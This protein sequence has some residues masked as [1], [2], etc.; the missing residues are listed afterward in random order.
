MPV[1]ANLGF[2]RDDGTGRTAPGEH[3]VRPYDGILEIVHSTRF[4]TTPSA[5]A[6]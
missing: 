2:A 1:G 3:K 6:G 5:Y 4:L